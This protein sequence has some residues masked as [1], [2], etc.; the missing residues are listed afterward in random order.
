[1]SNDTYFIRLQAHHRVLLVFEAPLDSSA[2]TRRL[3]ELEHVRARRRK[4]TTTKNN[5]DNRPNAVDAATLGRI[6]AGR[7]LD[8][9]KVGAGPTAG[10]QP[11]ATAAARSPFERRGPFGGPS[12]RRNWRQIDRTRGPARGKLM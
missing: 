5:N 8:S 12:N 9:S 2:V 6:R 10:Q 11:Q 4:T 3:R 1:M 7:N